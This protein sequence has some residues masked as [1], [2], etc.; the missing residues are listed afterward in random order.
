M[1]SEHLRFLLVDGHSVIHAWPDLRKL[2]MK[3]AQRYMAREQLLQRMRTLQDMTSERVVVIFD[4][5]GDA[6]HEERENDGVQI[7]YSG[8]SHSADNVIERL[9]AKYAAVHR[10][11]VCTA[12]RMIWETVTSLG[13][14]W[15]S[16]EDLHF[17]LGRAEGDLRDRLKKR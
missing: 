12:D 2:H 1:S 14:G 7:F 6:T 4:G 9:V 15:L 16:P 17:E 3:T 5:K 13:S 11:R 10:V 8:G